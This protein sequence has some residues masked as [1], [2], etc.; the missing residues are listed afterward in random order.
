MTVFTEQATS[1]FIQVNEGEIQGQIHVNDAGDSDKVVVMFH[2]SGPGASGWSNFHRNVDS[3]VAGGYRVLLIDSPGFNKSYPLVT[4]SRDGAYAQAAK[5]VMDQL[6][7]ARAHLIGNSMGAATAM[8]M[9]MDYPQMVDRLV[10][11]GGGSVGASTSTPM[12]TEGLKRL[13]GL[14]R[15]PSLENLRAMLDIFVYAPST[16]TEE[17][18]QGRWENMQKHPEH[19]KNFVESLKVSTGRSNYSQQLANLKC[20]TLII[21]GRD[22]RFVPMDIGMRMLWG[23]PNADLHVFSQCGHWAQWEHA[24]KFN[25]LVLN[26]FSAE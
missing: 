4:K 17:L 16:L 1:R 15:Q 18:I 19:L 9:A 13:Q 25:Q 10:M 21:W 7:I 23:M 6:G 5:G 20:N 8:R 11:M 14:Y 24:A 12:P 22:D 3:L 2:G 26:F